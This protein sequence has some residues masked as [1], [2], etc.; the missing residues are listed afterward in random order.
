MWGGL[1]GIVGGG[2]GGGDVGVT[3]GALVAYMKVI[4]DDALLERIECIVRR[5]YHPRRGALGKRARK[6]C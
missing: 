4:D 1:R 3:V 2:V 5:A 6:E